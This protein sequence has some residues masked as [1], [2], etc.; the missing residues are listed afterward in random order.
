MPPPLGVP[1]R[2]SPAKSHPRASYSYTDGCCIFDCLRSRSRLHQVSSAHREPADA[3]TTHIARS[4]RPPETCAYP[5]L[6]H[7][8]GYKI[9][10]LLAVPRRLPCNLSRLEIRMQKTQQIMVSNNHNQ[11]S[12]FFTDIARQ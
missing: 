5:V 4:V 7:I 1:Q 8:H 12:Q 9:F 10:H 2:F 3:V 6:H 11:S